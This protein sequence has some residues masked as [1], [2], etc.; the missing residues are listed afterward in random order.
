MKLRLLAT[1]LIGAAL[2]A[3]CGGGDDDHDHDGGSP[4]SCS[5]PDRKAWLRD[6]MADWYFWY[7]LSPSPD[8]TGYFT[9][10]EYFEA[11]LYPG[12]TAPNADFPS[13]DRW[14]YLQST[15]SFDRFYGDGETLGYGVFV[16]GDEVV[17]S[18]Q[19]PLLV[20]YVEPMSPA[21]AAGVKRGDRILAANGRQA[22]DIIAAD[23]FSVLTPGEEGD[24][25]TLSL[26]DANGDR[27][28][29]LTAAVFPLV[30]V[31]TATFVTSPN[32]R[33]MGYIV[34]KDMISQAHGPMATA[35]QG[36]K[37]QGVQEIVIDLRYNGGG[38]V[39]TAGRVASQA[40]GAVADGQAFAS[41]LYNDRQASR[42]QTF[43]FENLSSSLAMTRVYVLTGH[44]TCSAS[45]Q[46]INGLRGVG[47]D[48]V[49]IGDTTCG[50]PVGFLPADDGCGTTYSAVN[51]ESVNARLE[52]RYFDGFAPTE[53][54][55]GSDTCRVADDFT[56]PL[57][58]TT[59][60]LLAAAT[61]HADTGACGY[62]P[63][64]REQALSVK[65]WQVRRR[66]GEPAERTDM[67]GR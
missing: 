50:K 54:L 20:R 57:G 59:E 24:L 23:D 9:V 26:R 22:S 13:F 51:F 7:K 35:F 67:I 44:R 17:G 62:V 64:A 15:Q 33:K 61:L 47:V 58:T 5:V 46:V 25:L 66:G 65:R 56:T 53:R 31:P 30:P 36:F 42:N 32:G 27:D 38:L 2:M 48:V 21:A 29:V 49:A 14:S 8:P 40:A 16:A 63:V 19:S 55:D 45:E 10:D 1:S 4:A 12:S 11:L 52:G 3:A 43:A 39:S 28:V 18:P 6:Y 41:L 37:L 34:V 60:P